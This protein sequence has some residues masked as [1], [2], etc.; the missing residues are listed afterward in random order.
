MDLKDI[1][2][3]V[4]EETKTI[5]SPNFK[6]EVYKTSTLPSLDDSDITFE[7]FDEN[8]K[9]AKLI[10]TCVLY[11][12]I[13][14]STELN[15]E[16][17]PITLSRLYSS[18]VRGAIKCGMYYGGKVRNIIGDRVMF[19]F[20]SQDC[21]KNAVNAAI[22]LN[23]FSSYI[24]NK[25]F[26]NGNIQCGIGI[27]YG[28]MLAAKTG[29]I[30]RNTDTT[31]YKSLVWLGPPANI[32][33]KLADIANKTFTRKKISVGDYYDVTGQWLWTDKEYEEFFDSLELTYSRPMIAK[34]KEPYQNVFAWV[35]TFV[36]ESYSSILMTKNVYNGFK[37][38]CPDE[39]SV[40]KGWWELRR[41]NVSGYSGEI[42]Q[43]NIYFKFVDTLS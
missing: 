22:L 4:N 27:D 17:Y 10:E 6:I 12:D 13:R 18:F 37:L 32:A 3:E 11:I 23:T 26:K 7:N 30:K 8:S 24:L 36:T 20:D 28:K 16:Q 5:T 25:H 19:L 42:Y 35:K 41:V 2:M 9:K 14:Q 31:E 38:Q 33:S 29:T 40:K 1:L 39:E 34:F 43:G 21:F 15:M